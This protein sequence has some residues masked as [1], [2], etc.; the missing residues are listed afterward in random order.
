MPSAPSLQHLSR[1]ARLTELR[2]RTGEAL[3]SF[4]FGLV[5]TLTSLGGLILHEKLSHGAHNAPFKWLIG[6]TIASGVCTLGAVAWAYVRR[7]PDFTGAIRLDETHG[8]HDRV[9]SALSFATIPEGDRSPLMQAAIDD[10]LEHGGGLS[11]R[12]A[13]PISIP[14]DLGVAAL[15]G[16]LLVG[17]ST[18]QWSTRTYLPQARTIDA[19]SLSQDD[20]DI[21]RDALK[22]LADKEQ[23]P[24]AQAAIQ[25]FNQLL[26]DL[27]QKRLDRAEAFRRMET[28]EREMLKNSQ[29]DSKAL[30]DALKAT[31]DELKKSPIS[32]PA[33]EAL[34]KKDLAQAEKELKDLAKRLRDK[35]QKLSEED[36]K[37]LREALANA[38]KK[39]QEIIQKLQQKREE[40][41][42]SLLQREQKSS[43][44]QTDEER[45]LL[46]RDKRELERLDREIEEKERAQRQLDRL[47]R[48]LSQ[49]AEDL[50]K[51]LG[52]S[53]EDLE[54]GAEDINRMAKEEMSDKE[55]EELRQRLQELR[56]QLR[57]EGQGGEELR[58]RLKK[59]S[60]RAHGK[61]G[62]GE[63]GESGQGGKKKG[64][65]PGQ[66][67]EGEGED[68][69]EG[70]GKEGEK[71]QK[72]KKGQ[73][74]GE[75]GEEEG[76]GEGEGKGQ[77]G[78]KKGIKLQA[79]S[80]SG[81]GMGQGQMPGQG[82]GQQPGGQGQQPG[83][84]GT[85]QGGK[86]WGTG[87]DDSVA[88]KSTSGK[89]GTQDAQAQAADTGQ[90]PS[91]S[92]TI[93]SAADRGFVGKKY[94]RVYTDYKTK[95]EEAMKG[96]DI[97]AGYKFYVQRYFQLIRPRE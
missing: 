57:Q 52:L 35:K 68:E 50:M 76:E 60:K 19:V 5:P 85:G 72:G 84:Q 14:G 70:E 87:H 20:L 69:E 63:E 41:R 86:Q 24:E 26:E 32:K 7:Y 97:P 67:G 56:E 21:Y 8:L 66:E 25:Q 79:G 54:K 13:A 75:E 59:F 95:A 62:Q 83:G 61:Q 15:I 82:A 34:A 73:K 47:D 46:Q 80:G 51:E 96:E 40:M 4:S 36:K 58:K 42:A 11:S 6:S 28:L 90:G 1:A 53:A 12:R 48:E 9:T 37:K 38:A 88:G 18:L 10:A 49:A 94:K 91:V 39:Q 93:V 29:A 65:K 3:R 44:N 92:E 30:G 71:G 27:A 31:A 81:Q 23:S 16:M 45:R 2:L 33:G 74:P 77:G 64:Q 89:F 55:K 43:Q 22:E 17:L 78:K